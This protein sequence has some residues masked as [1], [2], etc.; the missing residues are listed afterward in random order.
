[1]KKLIS[2]SIIA[3]LA[4]GI[5]SSCKT[6]QKCPAYTSNQNIINHTNA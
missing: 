4:A 5:F 3:I 6:H 2:L 1:M